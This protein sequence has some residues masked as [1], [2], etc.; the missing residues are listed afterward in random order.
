MKILLTHIM[1]LFGVVL[2]ATSYTAST[3]G[4]ANAADPELIILDWGGYDDPN[5]F[6]DYVD[7]YGDVPSYSFFS[8]VEEGFQKL[9][10]GF[11][12]DL[13]HPCAQGVVKWRE[14]GLIKP[15]DTS[16]L[17]NWSKVD[18]Q[19]KQINGFNVDGTHWVVPMDWGATAL[20]Y[21]SDYVNS[22][23]RNTLMSFADPKFKNKVSIVDNV[24]DAYALGFLAVGVTDWN[25]ATEEDFKKASAFLR[26]VHKNVRTYWQ[27]GSEI[28][29][30]M[31]SGEVVLSWSWNEVAVLLQ[32][33]GVPVA[34]NQEP[35]EGSSTWICG[36]VLLKDPQGD[37]QKAYDFIDAFL[38]EDSGAF[39]VN[40]W[41][42]GHSN[43]DV[44]RKHGEAAGFLSLEAYS[45]NKLWQEPLSPVL[46]G[47]MVKEFE[48]IKAG[49]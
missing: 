23:D 37:E 25:K 43:A 47:R 7:K 41:G 42:Y 6:S 26:K 48:L 9:R 33:E 15:I 39:L 49:F 22:K 13:G 32:G 8:D 28:R 44:M 2:L 16:R 4:P 11:K 40:D 45:H 35:L 30:L 12:A 24:N 5:F 10:A 1:A 38:E 34:M 31:K 21:H 14:A 36:Y 29:S 18:E 3:A 27:D 19:F 20:T 17:K 46:H